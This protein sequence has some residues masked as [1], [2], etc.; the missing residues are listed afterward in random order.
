MFLPLLQTLYLHLIP[1]LQL[2]EHILR[3]GIN[4]I[5]IV[6]QLIC[7]G[8]ALFTLILQVNLCP[9]HTSMFL[10]DTLVESADLLIVWFQLCLKSVD[11]GIP[12]RQ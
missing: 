1:P 2:I 11:L 10:A 5:P 12:F 7:Q 8:P 4:E 9:L 6:L 3:T